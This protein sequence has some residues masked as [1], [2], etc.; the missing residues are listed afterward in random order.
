M[1][2]HLPLLLALALLPS[3]AP[4]ILDTRAPSKLDV[5]PI[6]IVVGES[7]AAAGKLGESVKAVGAAAGE[8]KAAAGKASELTGRLKDQMAA[9]RILAAGNAELQAALAASDAI[10]EDISRANMELTVK[11]GDLGSTVARLEYDNAALGS[12]HARLAA[13]IRVLE[14]A[15]VKQDAE[16]DEAEKKLEHAAKLQIKYEAAETSR[17]WWRSAAIAPWAILLLLLLL[18]VGFH[19]VKAYY[20]KTFFFARR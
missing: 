12:A 18:Y 20:E 7:L 10:I 6:A 8:V 16:I 1:K 17:K 4:R 13:E 3:C 14:A 2:T 9:T 5:I 15:K 11:L 19:L